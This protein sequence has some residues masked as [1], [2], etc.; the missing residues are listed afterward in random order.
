MLP[1]LL[2]GY[3]TP[4]LDGF[5]KGICRMIKSED[6]GQR[7]WNIV[8]IFADALPPGLFEEMSAHHEVGGE[9]SWGTRNVLYSF[10]LSMRP[11]L[12]LEIGAH[13][14]SGSVVIGAALKKNNFGQCYSLE[15]QDHYFSI[16]NMF[17]GKAGVTQFVVPLKMLSTD[18]GLA[19]AVKGEQVDMIFLD[20]CHTY[21]HVI[22]DLKISYNLLAD[23]GL[24]FLD[25]VGPEISPKLCE[26]GRGGVRQALLDFARERDDLQV[27]LLE[28]PFWLNAC[29]LAIACKQNRLNKHSPM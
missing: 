24:I 20:A 7:G 19:A 12:V 21:S 14:G 17:I 3:V 27:I 28:P 8:P 11:K 13:I 29:G 10:V 18:P 23:N 16:L 9:S 5:T 4:G 2:L 26:E 6:Y 22:S 25:D 1:V 15:P